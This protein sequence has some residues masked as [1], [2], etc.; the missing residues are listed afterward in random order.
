VRASLTPSLALAAAHTGDLEALQVL[1]ELVS[2]P[3][4][5]TRRECYLLWAEHHPSGHH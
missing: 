2:L 1:M 4:L 3:H 5:G